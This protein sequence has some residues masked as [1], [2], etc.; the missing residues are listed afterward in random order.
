VSVFTL[1]CVGV[2]QVSIHLFKYNNTNKIQIMNKSL[3]PVQKHHQVTSLAP[4][5]IAVGFNPIVRKFLRK[6]NDATGTA[7][8][9]KIYES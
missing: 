1:Y 9:F 7:P 5:I 8:H 2:N 3:A 4:T 6:E